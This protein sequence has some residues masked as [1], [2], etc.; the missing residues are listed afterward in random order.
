MHGIPPYPTPTASGTSA[1]T[2]GPAS[3]CASSTAIP[4][5]LT[6]SLTPAP[7]T[8]LPGPLL[9]AKHTVFLVTGAEKAQAVHGAFHEEYD[10]KR[11]PAQTASHDARRVA[12]FLDQA[13]AALM[14]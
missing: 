7:L 13:A 9:A 10:P 2:G 3:S 11:V 1:F 6:V 5:M 4:T 8:L 12:W 14:D